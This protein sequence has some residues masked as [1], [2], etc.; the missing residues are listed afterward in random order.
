LFPGRLVTGGLP[1]ETLRMCDFET[2]LLLLPQLAA[3]RVESVADQG[4]VL[5]VT[6]ATWDGPAPCTGCGRLSDWVHSG[7]ERHV[8]DEAV[9]GR[10]LRIDLRIRRLYCENPDCLKTTFAEQV[11]GLTRR[12][13]RRTPALQ[14]AV[15]AVAVALAGSAGARLLA[16]GLHLAL[17]WATMLNCLMRIPAP[18]R[19]VPRV[20]GIDEFA[21]LK[22]HRYA[23][24]LTNAVTGDRIDVLPDRTM[25]TV[26]AWLRAH[27][28]IEVVC[29]DGAAGFAQAVTDAD[30]AITQVGDRWHIWHTLCEA[31][32]KQVAAHS[33]CWAALGPPIREGRR[34]ETTRSAGTRY[35]TC[36]TRASDCWNARAG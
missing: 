5:V 3:V 23:S 7:Y 9:G 17:S 22:G 34:A 6:A 10:P 31:V 8:L 14:R 35:T 16:A 20:L 18:V 27:P 1:S 21:L 15:D 2:L 12:Y 11:T 32:H 28:G 30:P 25:D 24:I 4:G 29:R 13:Q 19:P 33:A 36:S 26:T